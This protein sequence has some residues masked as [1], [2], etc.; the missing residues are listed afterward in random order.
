MQGER[1]RQRGR[2]KEKRKKAAQG[3]R[4]QSMV[5]FPALSRP[6]TRIR[7]S[8]SP[9]REAKRRETKIPIASSFFTERHR[10]RERDRERERERSNKK[11]EKRRRRPN[12]MKKMRNSRI[13]H[14]VCIMYVF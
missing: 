6:K 12:K 5:V 3:V 8:F 7:A 2:E 13:S 14:Y 4:I 11:N 10:D 9:K 1:Q